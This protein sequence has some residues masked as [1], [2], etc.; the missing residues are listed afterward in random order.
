[1]S[2]KNTSQS[3]REIVRP[4]RFKR[5]LLKRPVS[6]DAVS[7]EA[8]ITG[9]S[10]S[11]GG[12]LVDESFEPVETS[13]SDGEIEI[14]IP[15]PEVGG[16]QGG[17]YVIEYSVENE[18]GDGS[19]DRF[20]YQNGV[21]SDESAGN[22]TNR[23]SAELERLS[24][25]FANRQNVKKPTNFADLDGNFPEFSNGF[26]YQSENEN[27]QKHD[28]E[29]IPYFSG[30]GTLNF[31]NPA[32]SS[33]A[34]TVIGVFQWNQNVNESFTVARLLQGGKN[35][36]ELKNA[37]RYIEVD[38]GF[39]DSI[40]YEE[41]T[42]QSNILVVACK[43]DPEKQ[44]GNGFVNGEIT[45]DPVSINSKT[46]SSGDASLEI[47]PEGKA[48]E[49]KLFDFITYGGA[50]PD[51]KLDKIIKQL[52][53]F[54]GADLSK[55][56]QDTF[57]RGS[58]KIQNHLF[59]DDKVMNY[60][61]LI[62]NSPVT[63]LNFDVTITEWTHP[64]KANAVAFGSRGRSSVGTKN[65]DV[66]RLA[67]GG[68]LIWEF[69]GHGDTVSSVECGKYDSVYSASKDG[70]VKKIG[71][72][73]SEVWNFGGHSG[74]V[75]DLALFRDLAVYSVSKDQ[76]V[77]R[78]VENTGDE[79]SSDF[80]FTGHLSEVNC[81][82]VDKNEII[83][84]GAENGELRVLDDSGN[85]VY[86]KSPVSSVKDLAVRRNSLFVL[87]PSEV[88]NLKT[89]NG[90]EVWKYSGGDIYTSVAVHPNGPIF[91]ST[92]SGLIVK[93]SEQGEEITT[94]DSETPVS[95]ISVQPGT[96]EPHWQS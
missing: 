91:V 93:L 8:N 70:T 41:F 66:I 20:F 50:V 35:Y 3:S 53:Y 81:V 95:D 92:A 14:A 96:Y 46:F 60:D 9:Y 25:T 1:M 87:S 44:I 36:F 16:V 71:P 89:I 40:L 26:E 2:L 43:I 34:S 49:P 74:E 67:S 75:T 38:S 65:N 37:Q 80:P 18:S 24:G 51:K 32:F 62:G 83:Y 6:E 4:N 19:V 90:K 52:G 17:D 27:F 29:S 28:G 13:V 12:Q 45:N 56:N 7:G 61:V 63:K 42:H 48:I 15:S 57:G 10:N 23:V 47:N 86:M 39:V 21:Y 94:F 33:R 79:D 54:Y 31:R 76:T 59:Y 88:K 55:V 72:R 84:T 85:E 58:P 68:D 11:F 77:R 69:T 64:R 22:L 5:V 30:S 78:I 73:G 82:E